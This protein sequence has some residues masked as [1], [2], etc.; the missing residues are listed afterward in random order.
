MPI[1]IDKSNIGLS[2]SQQGS[3][4]IPNDPVEI[5]GLLRR[6]SPD[7]RIVKSAL[8]DIL[9]TS[10]NPSQNIDINASWYDKWED[11]QPKWDRYVP[12]YPQ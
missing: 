6:L 12:D 7:N 9:R 11:Y 1:E 3:I 5:S 2:K 10:L 4:H 8:A